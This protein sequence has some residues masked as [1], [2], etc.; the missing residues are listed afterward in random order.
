MPKPLTL[1]DLA[2][3]N[4]WITSE[5][6]FQKRQ[7]FY[8]AVERRQEQAIADRLALQQKMLSI[9]REAGKDLGRYGA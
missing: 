9:V 7:A 5:E 8:E 3:W 6:E 1:E 4:G 2:R